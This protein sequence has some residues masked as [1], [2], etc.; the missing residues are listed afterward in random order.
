MANGPAGSS[1]TPLARK[2]G[3]RAGSRLV[4]CG[5]PS[6]WTIPDLPDGVTSR[7]LLEPPPAGPGDVAS[8]AGQ[9]PREP[10]TADLVVAFCRSLH[11][12]DAAVR[13]LGPVI[14]PAGLLWIAWPR[15]AGGHRSD[16]TDSLVRAA[17]LPTGLVDT[18]VAA[19]DTDWSA[20]RFV[21][22]VEHR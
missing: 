2:L 19:L 18:K 20:L 1:G 10:G 6:G 22:R 17:A 15:R 14:Y 12:V 13:G 21:W 9:G 11:E 8:R 3:V 5:A 4:L 16:A 7:A